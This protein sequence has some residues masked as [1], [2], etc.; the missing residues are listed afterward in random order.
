MTA[1]GD[2]RDSGCECDFQ[3]GTPDTALT[4]FPQDAQDA[5]EL[6]QGAEVDHHLARVFALHADFDFRADQVPELLL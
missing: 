4:G 2:L 5:V 3:P 6:F 1:A